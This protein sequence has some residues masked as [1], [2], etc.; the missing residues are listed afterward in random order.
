MEVNKSPGKTTKKML[1]HLLS[2]KITVSEFGNKTKNK[3]SGI[4][5][6]TV[7]KSPAVIIF[8]TLSGLFSA[9][10]LVISLETVIGVPEE[11]IVSKS[12]NTERA[13]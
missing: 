5:V 7:I 9:L 3:I 12:A 13:I 6:T 2:A 1:A 10:Y 8:F 11:Q 4:A